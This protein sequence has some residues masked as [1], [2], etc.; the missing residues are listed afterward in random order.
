MNGISYLEVSTLEKTE[1]NRAVKINIPLYLPQ[2]LSKK[3]GEVNGIKY[4]E[5]FLNYLKTGEAYQ[6]EMIRK[7]AKYYVHIT[8]ELPKTEVIYTGNNG[9][10]GI[11]TNP[12]GFAVTRIDNSGNYKGHTYLKEHELLYAKSNRRSNLCGELVKKVVEIAKS[13]GCGIAVEDLEFKR[14]RDVSRKFSRIKHQFIYFTLLTM[15]ESA[16]YKEGV[17][18]L[19][20]KPQYTSKIGLYKYCHQYG[21]IVHNG[22]AMVI[23]RRSYKYKEKVPK[24][25]RERLIEDKISFNEKNEWSKWNYINKIIKRKVGENPDF[26]LE[27]RKRIL[28]LV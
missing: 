11:D 22:A 24:A 16:C 18:L 2:K 14:D 19:K 9:M 8:F 6:V 21:M 17:E 15:L 12:N 3:T 7:E 25:L 1:S 26:W 28:G 27:N 5:M 20:V 13:N 4:R 23:A 10:I